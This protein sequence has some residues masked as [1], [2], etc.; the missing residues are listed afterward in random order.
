MGSRFSIVRETGAIVVG[1]TLVFGEM[2]GGRAEAHDMQ[3]V[4]R[5]RNGLDHATLRT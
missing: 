3:Q 4:G 5:L 1:C 2:T